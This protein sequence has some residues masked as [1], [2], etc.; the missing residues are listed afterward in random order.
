MIHSI[1]STDPRF[2]SVSFGPGLNIVLAE[3]AEG[4]SEKDSRN[5]LGKSSLIEIIQFCLGAQF[6]K[7]HPLA[8]P[9]IRDATYTLELDL[10]GNRFRVSRCPAQASTV[11][12]AGPIAL[13]TPPSSQADLAL[14]RQTASMDCAE[15]NRVLG[16][17]LFGLSKEVESHLFAPSFRG[18]IG[19]FARRGAHAFAQPFETFAKQKGWQV[20][21]HTAYLLQL[22]WRYPAR[23]QALRHEEKI[24]K[25]LRESAREG[26]RIPGITPTDHLGQ[27]EAARAD[28]VRHSEK[29]RVDLASFR[30]HPQYRELEIEAS[31]LTR[32]LHG[33]S[34]ANITSR[35]MLDLYQSTLREEISVEAP[36]IDRLYREAGFT[37]PERI[38]RRLEEVQ[39]FH[40]RLIKNRRTFLTEAIERLE[41]EIAQREISLT[42]MTNRRADLMQVLKTHG[43]LDEY[44]ML[45]RRM[46]ETS[47]QLADLNRRI[48]ATRSFNR[49]STEL[50]ANLAQLE[51]EVTRDFDER[52]VSLQAALTLFNEHSH[53]LYESPGRLIIEQGSKGGYR[54]DH[55]IPRKAAQAVG[56]MVVF[57]YDLMLVRLLRRRPQRTLGDAFLIHDSTLFDGADERQFTRAIELVHAVSRAEG[58]QYICCLNSDRIPKSGFT[59]GFHWRDHVQ[60]HL[61]DGPE[62]GGL[63]GFRFA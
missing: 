44:T 24:L 38:S 61:T 9:E 18:L 57:C 47:A 31:K 43:A 56:Q 34:S 10:A 46:L 23:G 62:S 8:K 50:K 11:V 17:V 26:V 53:A 33:L 36:E 16:R 21:V 41:F 35:E 59:D 63:F 4:S 60:I 58:F 27:L 15:W 49:K 42:E 28:L 22:D 55:E 20:Q 19:Y 37:L 54:F 45:Q 25:T 40:S 7:K 29:E 3:R 51:A 5:G 14:D 12:I 48:E 32:E 52:R 39:N 30:V 13:L 2:R 1:T 6:N